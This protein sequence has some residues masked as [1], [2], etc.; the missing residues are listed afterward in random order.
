MRRPFVIAAMVLTALAPASS[1]AAPTARAVISDPVRDVRYPT[2]N[3]QLL[4]P[5]HGLGM[6]AV[7][8]EASGKDPHP[9]VILMHGLPG[10]ERNLDLAQA[11]RRSGWDV[12]TF[13]YR[14]AWGS[15]G[16]FSIANAMDD[17]R[18]A[19]DF[20]R[21]P[22]AG[23]LGIDGRHLALAGH[24]M[25]GATAMMTAIGA[26][27]LDG[28]ILIDA[29]NIAHGTSKGATTREEL[30][31][32]FDDF[33]NSLHGATPASVADEVVAK[34]AQWD[35]V[36]AARQLPHLPIL[37]V[38]ATYGGALA[39]RLTTAALRRAGNRR[40]TAVEM[41]SDHSFSDHRIALASTIV[42]WLQALPR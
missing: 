3:Q 25:G 14:G 42:G 15:A 22:E 35:L 18:A 9:T 28:L 29:W 6:N 7:L 37:T 16:D 24:S 38:T 13:T 39:N 12:L 10:N 41:D 40:V 8:F 34:R 19:L 33:G 21:S 31:N 32:G 27:D 26:R 17:T 5:S 30:I 11:I 23:K 2:H 1:L 4:I 20:A 36:V